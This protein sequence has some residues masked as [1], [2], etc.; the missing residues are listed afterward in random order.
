MVPAATP[1]AVVERLNREFNAALNHPDTRKR[2]AELSVE[3]V[4]GSPE[5][6]AE[7]MRTQAEAWGRLIRELGIRGT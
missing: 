7:F 6:L 2:F 4:G 3:P 1:A 5:R